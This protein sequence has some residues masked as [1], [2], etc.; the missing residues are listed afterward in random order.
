MPGRRY[1]TSVSPRRSTSRSVKPCRD[2]GRPTGRAYWGKPLL[3]WFVVL[4]FTAPVFRS[5]LKT[6]LTLFGWLRNHTVWGDP[7]EFIPEEAYTEAFERK[8]V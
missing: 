7:I 4:A 2:A 1:T 5:G 6:N 3:V 8:N